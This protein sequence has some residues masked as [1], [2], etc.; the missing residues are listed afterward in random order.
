[1][2]AQEATAVWEGNLREGKG[3]FDVKSGVI[4]AD[5]TFVSRFEGQAGT[6]PEELLGAA[7]AACY[8]MALSAGLGRA[9]FTP[10][11]VSTTAKVHLEKDDSGFSITRIDLVTEAEVPDLD[12]ATFMEHA[13]Q[14][15]ETCIISR[16]LSAVEMTLEAKL[17]S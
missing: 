4:G 17:I 14:T 12:E 7:H 3:H 2:A 11:K 9:G 10:T 16:A 1:M 13:N 6:N 8:S 5:Y 15:K